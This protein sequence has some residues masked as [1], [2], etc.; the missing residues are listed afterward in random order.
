MTCEIIFNLNLYSSSRR[1]EQ[2]INNVEMRQNKYHNYSFSK[3]GP[4]YHEND[5]QLNI[6]TIFCDKK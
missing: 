3:M 1:I 2:K 4:C 6:N 5:M